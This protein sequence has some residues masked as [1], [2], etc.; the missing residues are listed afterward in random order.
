MA[1]TFFP[2]A[3]TRAATEYVM[4]LHTLPMMSANETLKKGFTANSRGALRAAMGGFCR[5]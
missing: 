3:T 5:G 1:A 4:L 2:S